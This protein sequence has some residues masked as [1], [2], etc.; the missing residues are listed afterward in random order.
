MPINRIDHDA[1]VVVAAGRG[2]LTDADVFDYQREVWFIQLIV[3]IALPILP[4]IL[5]LMPL[6]ELI[7]KLFGVIF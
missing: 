3:I 1:R 5:T 2:V 6:E 4:L 7:T